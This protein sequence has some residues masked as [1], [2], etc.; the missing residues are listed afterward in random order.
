[1]AVWESDSTRICFT[2]FSAIVVILK[3]IFKVHLEQP[4]PNISTCHKKDN[5]RYSEIIII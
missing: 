1:M 2:S 3:I 5:S 4:T